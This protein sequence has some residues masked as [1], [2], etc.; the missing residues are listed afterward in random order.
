ME[1]FIEHFIMA[2]SEHGRCHSVFWVLLKGD[3]ILD[4]HMNISSVQE[5]YINNQDP[6]IG[7]QTAFSSH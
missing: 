6:I 3:H 1:H 4:H 5:Y 2:D 7:L